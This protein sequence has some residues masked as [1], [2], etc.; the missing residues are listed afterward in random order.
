M[1]SLILLLVTSVPVFLSTA[2]TKSGLGTWLNTL[3]PVSSAMD[4]LKNMVINGHSLFFTPSSL[5]SVLAGGIIG[6]FV[7]QYGISRLEF[8]GGE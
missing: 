7:L 6:L 4:L 2:M 8:K 5:L 3:S 1:T